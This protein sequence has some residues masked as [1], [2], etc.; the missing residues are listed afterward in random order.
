MPRLT[1]ANV[2]ATACLI[3]LASVCAISAVAQS[4]SATKKLAACYAK[5]GA[6]KGTMRYLAKASGKCKRSEKKV[7]WNQTGPQ[8][9]QGLTGPAGSSSGGSAP[10]GAIMFFDLG[11]C[12]SG[13]TA[14]ENARGRYLVGMNNGGTLGVGVGN[15]LS[16]LENRPV[17]QHSHG[18]TD[19]G[20]THTINGS[21]S[22]LQVPNAIVSFNGRGTMST[23]PGATSAF[24]TGI[25]PAT[26]GITIDPAGSVAGTNAPFVQLLA[27]QKD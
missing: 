14:Y 5:K 4:G 7:T 23:L 13:W 10:S 12:P 16:D 1:Y 17:G 8:G 2:V 11:T 24:T 22:S 9:P 18:V 27:C 6:K 15:A 3:G 25:N 20:H 19:P 21:G 26:T